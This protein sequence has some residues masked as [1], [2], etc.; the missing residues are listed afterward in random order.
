LLIIIIII[1]MVVKKSS[2][3]SSSPP[4]KAK[5]IKKNNTGGP[6][7]D[8]RYIMIKLKSMGMPNPTRATVSDLTGYATGTLGNWLSKYKK[9]GQVEMD[10]KTCRIT[11]SG[12]AAVG[13]TIPPVQSNGEMQEAMKELFKVSGTA[14]KVFD[15][16]L[17]DDN[18]AS[19]CDKNRLMK[20][21]DCNNDGTFTNVLSRLRK[22][23]LVGTVTKNGK[24][25]VI[26]C[27]D[28]CFP[29]AVEGRPGSGWMSNGGI[30]FAADL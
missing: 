16:L 4:Y 28:F 22:P 8:P 1:I 30:S 14:L 29:F 24:K 27:T 18:I 11:R 12:E 15:I 2:S 7:I 5:P 20:A 21:V 19:G 13:I 25:N 3:S 26:C 9:M 23:G 6:K 10:G 17:K